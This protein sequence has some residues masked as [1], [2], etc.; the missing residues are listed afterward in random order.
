MNLKRTTRNAFIASDL[1]TTAAAWL[2]FNIVR[3]DSLPIYYE[4]AASLPEWLM[5]PQVIV[6]QM[7][8]PICM[9]LLYML[10]GAYNQNTTV[11]SSRLDSMLNTLLVSGTGALGIYF[12]V[13]MNDTIPERMTAYE[14][15]AILFLL[16]ACLTLIPRWIIIKNYI[17][18]AKDVKYQQKALVICQGQPQGAVM[19]KLRKAATATGLQIVGYAGRE[20]TPEL[21]DRVS[22]EGI[23]AFIVLSQGEDTAGVV[24]FIENIYGL[25]KSIFLTPDFYGILT[26]KPRVSSIRQEPLVELTATAISPFTANLK[27]LCDILISAGVLVTLA[28]G[29]LLVG[30]LVRMSSPGGALY[31]QERIGLHGKPFKIIKF[32]TMRADA[33]TDTPRLSS[34]DDDRVTP[35]GR[36]MRKFRIDEFPQFWNVLKGEMSLVGPRPER[37]YYIRHIVRTHPAYALLHQVRPGITSWGMVKYGYAKNVDEMIERLQYDLLYVQNMSLGIDI[38]IMIHTVHTVLTGKGV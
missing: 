17:S 10:S 26:M 30:M 8:V 5:M 25:D 33:E 11:R 3:Y 6:G 18:K 15:I 27:R 31:R 34:E 19:E 22:T 21:E 20:A 28:P 38:K 29:Y 32:R 1:I 37:A 2:A 4:D 12:G 16:L 9:I 14:L 36:W 24:S 23:Q 13:L 35:L 7:V